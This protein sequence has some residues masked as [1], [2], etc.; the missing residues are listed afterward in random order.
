MAI[1]QFPDDAS[2]IGILRLTLDDVFNDR[3]FI[4]RKSM[5]ACQIADF[6]LTL[7]LQGEHDLARLKASV[8]TKLSNE[9]PARLETREFSPEAMLEQTK[10]SSQP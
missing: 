7:I 1:D 9:L 3:R 5:S 4:A 10:P 8:F 6:I 2:A